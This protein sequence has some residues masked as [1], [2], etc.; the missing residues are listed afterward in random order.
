[1]VHE[2]DKM[3]MSVPMEGYFDEAVNMF[4]K[5]DTVSLIWRFVNQ[6]PAWKL[7]PVFCVGFFFQSF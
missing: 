7:C 4:S 3:E 1:M 5:T 6:I 2:N